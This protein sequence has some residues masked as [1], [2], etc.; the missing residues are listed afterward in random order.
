MGQRHDFGQLDDVGVRTG[1]NTGAHNGVAFHDSPLLGIQG[2]GFLQDAVGQGELANVVHK[3][4]MEKPIEILDVPAQ[5]PRYRHCIVG[6]A[7]DMF[8]GLIVL[9]FGRQTQTQHGVDGTLAQPIESCLQF[10][11]AGLDP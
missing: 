10:S 11:G 3:G 8:S 5:L 6:H 4:G 1:E 2:S 7:Q 9:V